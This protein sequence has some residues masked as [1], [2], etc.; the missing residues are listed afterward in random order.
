MAEHLYY[1]WSN[2]RK[3]TVK[4]HDAIFGHEQGNA[5][6]RSVESFLAYKKLSHFDTSVSDYKLKTN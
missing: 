6:H 4:G 2:Q 3:D 5:G 1:S